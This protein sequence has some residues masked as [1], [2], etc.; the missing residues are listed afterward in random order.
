MSNL[1]QLKAN[2]HTFE[3][4]K[5]L[6]EE[7]MNVL[8]GIADSMV[9]K[10]VLPCTACRYCVTHCP[11]KLDIPNLLSLYNEHVFT[12][13]RFSSGMASTAIGAIK[14]PPACVGCRSCEAVCPQQL[15]I[16]EAMKDFVQKLGM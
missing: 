8:L 3:E 5:P 7:E 15:K 13:G 14:P 12:V 16:S 1:E 11:K 4:E 2:V 6:N 10:D 9:K